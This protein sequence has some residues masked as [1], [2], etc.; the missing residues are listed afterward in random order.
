VRQPSRQPSFAELGRPFRK[1]A[2]TTAQWQF[3]ERFFDSCIHALG[4][5][6]DRMAAVERGGVNVDDLRATA[7]EVEADLRKLHL[8]ARRHGLVVVSTPPRA[9][10]S[11]R[12]HPERTRR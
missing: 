11:R 3:R 7:D 1:P 10:R 8:Q 6:R 2:R 12:V 4:H 9:R 5:M